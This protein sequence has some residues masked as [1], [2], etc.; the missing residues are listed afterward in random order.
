MESRYPQPCSYQV[1]DRLLVMR[2]SLAKASA[3]SSQDK[4]APRI[5]T[6]IDWDIGTKGRAFMV[7]YSHSGLANP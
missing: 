3:P 1:E 5:F 7:N 2:S 4:P 6:V